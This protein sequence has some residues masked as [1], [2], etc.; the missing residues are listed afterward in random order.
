MKVDEMLR[1][2]YRAKTLRPAVR[3]GLV[4]MAARKAAP[5]KPRRRAWLL[6]AAS[7]LAV[8][9]PVAFWT[10]RTFES[11]IRHEVALN[12][13]QHS[14]PAFERTQVDELRPLMDDLEFSLVDSQ[15]LRSKE[16]R[17][18]GGRYCSIQ[19]R[20]A[21]QLQFEDSLGGRWTLFQAPLD[22]RLLAMSAGV[23]EVDGVRV[24]LWRE[25]GVLLALAS[26]VESQ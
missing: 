9:L 18:V 6:I 24:E 12:H 25:S 22:P 13:L 8:V 20:F 21:A 14:A 2:H 4:A 11:A 15:R 1:Q 5:A 3:E 19:G 10:L 17:L 23:G 7:L 16:L 26:D